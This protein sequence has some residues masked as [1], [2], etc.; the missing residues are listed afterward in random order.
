MEMEFEQAAIIGKRRRVDAT[1]F[2][3]GHMR[4]R[5]AEVCAVKPAKNAGLDARDWEPVGEENYKEIC[6]RRG[7]IGDEEAYLLIVDET[8]S[9]KACTQKLYP[10]AIAM[11]MAWGLPLPTYVG[12]GGTLL[13]QATDAAMRK[14]QRV[15]AEQEV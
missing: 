9:A 8:G 6:I 11:Q 4:E 3:S 13:A 15:A 7:L 2:L 1:L 10:L 12:E 14:A 5:A